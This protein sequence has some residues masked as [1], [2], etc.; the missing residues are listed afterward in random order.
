M[1]ERDDFEKRLREQRPISMMEFMYPLMQAYDSVALGADVE[2]GGTDQKFNLLV[3][4]TIQERYGRSRR[5]A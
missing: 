3:A 5:S 4:R 2:L 1:L